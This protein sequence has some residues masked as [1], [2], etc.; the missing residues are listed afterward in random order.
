MKVVFFSFGSPLS[1]SVVSKRIFE[2]KST[3]DNTNITTLVLYGS[4]KNVVSFGSMDS[5]AS[6]KISGGG[7]ASYS[8]TSGSGVLKFGSS[9]GGS[10]F[11]TFPKIKT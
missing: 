10:E 8:R 2:I 3:E 4:D 7:F 5:S 1:A 11:T 6:P 9:K